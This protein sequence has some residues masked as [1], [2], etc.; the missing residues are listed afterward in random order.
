MV[1]IVT[2]GRVKASITPVMI[3]VT[4]VALINFSRMIPPLE[5]FSK[6]FQHHFTKMVAVLT[7]QP[8]QPL[9]ETPLLH[10]L[11]FLLHPRSPGCFQGTLRR[12]QVGFCVGFLPA[13]LAVSV[14]LPPSKRHDLSSG[15]LWR[16]YLQPARLRA[17][18]HRTWHLPPQGPCG[19]RREPPSP[20]QEPLLPG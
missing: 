16:A 6:G 17:R 13:A 7:R 2:G 3:A 5:P 19:S 1:S 18:L 20:C 8:V 10:A 12:L 14:I 11:P 4:Q 15:R 9:H